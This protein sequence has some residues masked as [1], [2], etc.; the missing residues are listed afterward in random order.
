MNFSVGKAGKGASLGLE[1]VKET[2]SMTATGANLVL[3]PA[4]WSDHITL[5]L[6]IVSLKRHDKAFSLL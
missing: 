5:H 2:L 3:L 1:M 4:C 6:I